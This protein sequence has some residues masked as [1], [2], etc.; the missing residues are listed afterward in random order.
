MH[1]VENIKAP[2]RR[3]HFQFF[4]YVHIVMCAV[5]LDEGQILIQSERRF[6]H[7]CNDGEFVVVLSSFHYCHVDGTACRPCQSL[8]EWIYRV[9]LEPTSQE[10]TH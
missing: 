4:H 5:A 3:T 7:H 1:I 8:S 2:L 6:C 10:G 9:H